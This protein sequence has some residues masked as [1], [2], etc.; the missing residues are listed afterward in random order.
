MQQGL[1]PQATACCM[2]SVQAA[3]RTHVGFG[4]FLQSADYANGVPADACVAGIN[5][6]YPQSD[7]VFT[8]PDSPNHDATNDLVV[9]K[10]DGMPHSEV[11]LLNLDAP[12]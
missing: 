12:R 6:T 5:D 7:V 4:E 11:R 10:L 8:L 9:G 3:Y 2:R 1:A